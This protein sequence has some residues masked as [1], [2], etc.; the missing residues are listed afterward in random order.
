MRFLKRVENH[1]TTSPALY[2]ARGSV[3]LLLTKNHPVP[4]P[5][6]PE[7]LSKYINLQ[8]FNYVGPTVS[9]I[10]GCDIRT[11]RQTDRHDESI[12]AISVFCHLATEP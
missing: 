1:P 12:R 9:D 7:R 8:S 6:F 10:N 4:T 5:T 2:E 11:E 3:R